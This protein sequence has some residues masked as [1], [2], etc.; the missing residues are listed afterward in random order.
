[1]EHALIQ[2]IQA[3]DAAMKRGLRQAGD[4]SG[5]ARLTLPQLNYLE[6]IHQMESPTVTGLAE[7]LHI[8]KASTTVGIQRLVKL[9]FVEK[10]PSTTDRRRIDLRL[11]PAGEQ[12]AQTRSELFDQITRSIA[13]TLTDQ[14]AAQLDAILRKL[15][16]DMQGA[17]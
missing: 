14:E 9:G 17:E 1:M 6:A 10:V 16:R 13:H 8:S 7:R 12:L 2:F 15:V 3:L 5:F 4:G 11:T